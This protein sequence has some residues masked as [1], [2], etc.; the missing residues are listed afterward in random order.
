MINFCEYEEEI[1]T[2]SQ[3]FKQGWKWFGWKS[4][5]T[6]IPFQGWNWFIHRTSSRPIFL[7]RT[8]KAQCGFMWLMTSIYGKPVMSY[9]KLLMNIFKFQDQQIFKLLGFQTLGYLDIL[10]HKIDNQINAY[11]F[12]TQRISDIKMFRPS[13]CQQQKIIRSSDNQRFG[14]TN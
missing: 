1:E 8:R 11:H 6:V 13:V 14:S 10:L 7:Y 4:V 12:Q 2:R 5:V 3:L 9:Q